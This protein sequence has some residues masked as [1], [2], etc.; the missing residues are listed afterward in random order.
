MDIKRNYLI[1]IKK[2]ELTEGN[3]SINLTQLNDETKEVFNKRGEFIL[4]TIKKYPNK[5]NKDE[6]IK[7]SK[8]WANIRFKGC[9]YPHKTYN[10]IRSI[11][12]DL[13]RKIE[14]FEEIDSSSENSDSD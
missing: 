7:Y 9:K 4:S 8:I 6:L 2:M 10:I 13:K 14:D 12:N 11:T 1:L 3:L 5:Y